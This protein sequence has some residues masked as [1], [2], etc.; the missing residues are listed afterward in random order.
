M[1]PEVTEVSSGGHN[2]RSDSVR[3][4][5]ALGFHAVQSWSHENDLRSELS[6]E[7]CGTRCL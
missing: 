2:T 5:S 3:R 6:S 7:R 4:D 1:A